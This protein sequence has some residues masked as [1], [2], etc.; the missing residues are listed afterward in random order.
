MAK[1][2]LDFTGERFVPDIDGVIRLEH[3]HRYAFARDLTAGRD[4]LDIACGEGY[5]SAMISENANSVIGV[6]IA[7][8][9]IAYA[10]QTYVREN[11]NF[12]EGSATKIPV[13]DAS[14]DVVV[15][16]ETIEH[17]EDH[18]AMLAEIKRVLRPGGIL[19]ISSPNK[20][21]YS[22]ETGYSNPYHVKELYTEEFLELV[23]RYFKNVR[24]YAQKILAA[25]VIANTDSVSPLSVSADMKQDDKFERRRYDMIVASSKALPALAN[26]I[27][28]TEE[29]SLNPYKSEEMLRHYKGEIDK[30]LEGNE[31]LL[32]EL[33]EKESAIN[34][35]YAV[36]AG[37]EA[38]AKDANSVLS[39][40]YWKR[41]KV[42]RN[43]SN[44]LRKIRKK[45]KKTW[46][47]MF[48]YEHYIAN[49]AEVERVQEVK[50]VKRLDL[51]PFRGRSVKP[52][53]TCI[54]MVRN[55][56]VRADDMMRHLCALFD[57]VVIIDHLS[58]DRTSEIV[59]RYNG[60]NGTQVV[61][62]K[63]TDVGY[64][65]SEY[66]SAVARALVAERQSDW[67]FFIDFDE[68]LPFESRDSFEQ[69]LAP[70]TGADVVN[71]HWHNLA[72]GEDARQSLQNAEV[73]VG[74]KVSPFVKIALNIPRLRGRKV[75]IAQGNHATYLD[76]NTMPY[77]GERAFGIF[78]APINGAASFR[79]KVNQGASAYAS[80]VGHQ[81][82]EGSH[83]R[84]LNSAASRIVENPVLLREIALRYGEPFD[85]V[86]ADVKAGRVTENTRPMTLK[87]AQ[88]DPAPF[89]IP[90]P[91]TVLEFDLGTIDTA[92]ARTFKVA[93]KNTSEI[94]SILSKPVYET[95]EP[96]TRKLDQDPLARA[97]RIHQ[98]MISAA[99][100]IE[101]VALP[102]AW[103]GHKAFL[104]SLMEAM[105][106]RRY[107]ELGSHAGASFF[108]A[109]Q[110]LKMN[111]GYGEAVAVDIWEGDH[112]AGF[113]DEHVFNNFKYLLKKH[114]PKNGSYIRGYFN[115]AVNLF[116]KK[117]ID[118]LHIDGLHTYE[119][120]KDDYETWLPALS[121]NG[122]ILF[123]DTSEYQGDFG[124]WQLFEEIK[125]QATASF[126]FRHCHG[127]G[128]M[129]FGDRETNPAIELLEHLAADPLRAE[130]YYSTLGSA[131]FEQALRR[132]S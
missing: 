46:P 14:V 58:T 112:Q 132:V 22:D 7:A 79:A 10:R 90:E 47:K 9:A 16:F 4:V 127:L 50:K 91:Q 97:S 63:A 24:H 113:Y 108:S 86:A 130:N 52:H 8:D 34:R 3:L 40:K 21:I 26:S 5:G 18:E 107:V 35:A 62:F 106:P 100:E 49:G 19:V 29:S 28:E 38:L 36:Q 129:A 33:S 109:C 73:T 111:D 120:V 99:T 76:G 124:V 119:A 117:S 44:I 65:Q 88:V 23:S 104:F 20:K 25:S 12:L 93:Y 13:A 116:E 95:L 126:R 87:F 11:L 98:A 94:E 114:F 51:I 31:R 115:Q 81:A 55:E 101:V 68:V 48:N 83:W 41:T 70:L 102:T 85:V 17:L 84:E 103:S 27:F 125:D 71:L 89:E 122:V 77:I 32:A 45:P 53:L 78:H 43:V 66:M 118:L 30:V 128:V 96:L 123:H 39:S 54:S 56:E 75:A 61:L 2:G 64:Y 15:S 131:L 110:H 57:R 42:L 72:T 74:P 59:A 82:S 69:A 92:M 60:H 67:V 37:I 121:E 80:T 1:L 6:D 105:R